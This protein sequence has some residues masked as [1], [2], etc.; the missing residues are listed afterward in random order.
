VSSFDLA[1]N[2]LLHNEGG[3]INPEDHGRGV[4]KWG[5]TLKTAR[6]FYIDCTP[7]DIMSMGPQ[8]AAAFYRMAFWERYHL[9]LIEDQDLATKML[10]LCV[11]MGPGTAI[12]MLQEAV[13]A[14]PDGV[15]GPVTALMVNT[16][17]PRVVLA[18]VRAL[19][20]LHYRELAKK[21][22]FAAELDGWL[23]RLKS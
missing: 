2:P 14:K 16:N 21:P 12:K 10:D 11:N 1:I 4:S 22:E 17:H 15:L 5:I 20:E 23:N 18:C 7:N 9:A 3:G 8:Q 19:A 13:H 6:E